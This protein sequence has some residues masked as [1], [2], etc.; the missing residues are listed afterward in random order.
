[1]H[2]AA[3]CDRIALA[4]GFLLACEKSDTPHALHLISKAAAELLSFPARLA[5]RGH[6]MI[7]YLRA[8]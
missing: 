8:Q 7:A 6:D 2:C 1:V 3:H 4:E 5:Q